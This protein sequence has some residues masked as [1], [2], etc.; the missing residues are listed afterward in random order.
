MMWV[1]KTATNAII[2]TNT[3]KHP[4][5]LPQREDWFDAAASKSSF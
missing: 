1:K 2:A 4:R 3:Q 5:D